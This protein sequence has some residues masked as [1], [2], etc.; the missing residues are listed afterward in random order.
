RPSSLGMNATSLPPAMSELPAAPATTCTD[1]P[2]ATEAVPATPAATRTDTAMP[3]AA[4]RSTMTLAL[5]TGVT[6]ATTNMAPARTSS[7]LP[8]TMVP[9][10]ASEA[11]EASVDWARLSCAR[12]RE[13]ANGCASD[14]AMITATARGFA[15][16]A[17]S[18]GSMPDRTRSVER[19]LRHEVARYNPQICE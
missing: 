17:I 4:S 13:T 8:P 6:D 18:G 10:A 7:A 5:A 2:M 12:A 16:M 14:R 9:E 3:V 19:T 1:W 11:R 15:F